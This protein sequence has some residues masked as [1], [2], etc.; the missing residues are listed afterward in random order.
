MQNSRTACFILV[1]ALLSLGLTPASFFHTT[2]LPGGARFL[3]ANSCARADV[4]A[5]IDAAVDGDVVLVPAGTCTWTQGIALSTPKAITIRGAG[6]DVTTIVDNINKLNGGGQVFSI[7]TQAGKRFRLT[8]I[9]FRGLAPDTNVYN[10]GTILLYG[11]SRDFRLDHLKFDKPGTSAFR[12]GGAMYGV[13]DHCYF[14]LSNFKQGNIVFHDE[15]GGRSWGDGSFAAPVELGTEQAVYIEDNVFIGSGYAGA[16]PLDSLGGGRFV[17]RH[18]TV[19]N[20]VIATHGTESSGRYRGVRSYEIYNNTF[21]ANTLLFT[22]ILL[23]G[24]TGVVWGNSFQGAGGQT[25][26]MSAVKL[27]NYRS[28]SAYQP[29]GRCGAGSPWDGNTDSLGYPCLDQVGRGLSTLISGDNPAPIGWPNQAS[30]PLYI[31][32]NT[33]SPVPQNPGELVSEQHAVIKNG[34]DYFLT[35]KPGYLPYTYPHPLT[36]E[37]TLHGAAADRAIKLTWEVNTTLPATSTWRIDYTDQSG[38][39]Y[40]PISGLPNPTR[41]YT[42]AGLTNYVPYTVTLSAMLDSS[43]FLSGRVTVIPTDHFVFL[44]MIR[45]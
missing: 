31:W 39:P 23:R 12:F 27:A 1:S 2:S 16:G 20:D 41:A 15:W 4:K 5:A 38:S 10:H 35:Q 28:D 42:L 34:R 22:G 30:E 19:Y 45:R 37:L 32:S 7:G 18:N 36:L 25:G 43:P 40:P 3:Q 6:M 17:F 24:G 11:T 33:W 14:D 29:W 26:Y 21:T 8:G 9:T 44:P 13:V